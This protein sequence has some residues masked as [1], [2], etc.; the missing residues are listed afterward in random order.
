MNE[1]DQDWYKFT[2]SAAGKVKLT[3]SKDSSVNVDDVKDG[4]IVYL[5]KT[6]SSKAVCELK[7]IQTTASTEVS[8]AKGTY[9]IKVVPDWSYAC[10]TRETYNLSV[11]YA[12][13]PAKVTGLKAT[14]G[15]KQVAL[16]WK[17]SKKADGYYIY[18]STSKKG[19]Y[20]KVATIK[21]GSTVK[22]TD[23]KLKAKKT[24]YYKV[25]AY[26]TDNGVTATASASAIVN[27][28]TK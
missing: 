16:K 9:Y 24:Y 7:E 25:V 22:Y 12:Q 21:K 14:A 27:K 5:Y 26:N 19:T 2:L 3:L 1:N 10:P 4:W 18:R 8:L 6:D 17:Q 15:K 23:K 11:K 28:K 13:T 20:T